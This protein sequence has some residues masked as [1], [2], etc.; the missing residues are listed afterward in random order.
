MIQQSYKKRFPFT[1]ATTSFIYPDHIAPNVEKLGPVIDE[2]ELILFESIPEDSLLSATDIKVMD[3][4]SKAYDVTYNI[5][6]PLDIS[7]TDKN[8]GLKTVETLHRII[9]DTMPLNPSTWTLHLP[10]GNGCRDSS[11]RSEWQERTFEHLRRLLSRGIDPHQISIE[12]LDYP[13]EWVADIIRELDLSVCLDIGHVILYGYDLES[14][15]HR[16]KDKITIIHLHGV[17]NRKDHIALNRMA[18]DNWR[19][20]KSLLADYHNVVSLEV[21]A[22]KHLAPSLD[23]LEQQFL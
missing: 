12:T 4:L 2:I 23:F 21:F 16:F 14:I 22:L 20:V 15:F 8:T 10:C 3:R 19:I 17:E 11:R 9:T 1:L 18:P 5:H 7:I 6:L 13:F